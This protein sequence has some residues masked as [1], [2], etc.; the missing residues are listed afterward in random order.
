[1]MVPSTLSTSLVAPECSKLSL[2]WEDN[3][4]LK[5]SLNPFK[6]TYPFPQCLFEGLN[7]NP[8]GLVTGNEGFDFL[9]S[10]VSLEHLRCG[11]EEEEVS[12]EEEHV[13]RYSM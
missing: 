8:K 10:R 13:K 4:C 2:L 6:H 5:P 12:K 7:P 9:R 3:S 11:L 1:M